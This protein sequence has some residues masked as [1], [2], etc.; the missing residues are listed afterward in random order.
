MTAVPLLVAL[1]LAAPTCIGEVTIPHTNRPANFSGA[2]GVYRIEVSAEPTKV[3]VEDPITLIV[4]IISQVPGP[5]PYPP[6]RD[7]LQLWPPE[8]E[9]N[10]FIEPLPELDRFMEREK[11]W[12]FTWRLMPKSQKVT[13]IPALEFVYYHTAGTPDFQAADGARSIALDVQPRPGLLL[14][15]P[16]GKR[17][18]FQQV[19]EGD[20]LL[21]LRPPAWARLATVAAGL[22]LP[23]LACV[24]A[25]WLW[26]RL[27]P[28]AAERLRR[29]RNRALKT[30][31]TQLGKL[32]GA[33]TPADVR[34]VLAGYLR[35]QFDLPPGEP[36]PSEVK[37]A[38]LLRGLDPAAAAKAESILQTFDATLFAPS[39]ARAGDNLKEGATLLMRNVEAEL[40]ARPAR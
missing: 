11:A 34:A 20:D 23:P 7:K 14:T 28:D 21:I 8:L 9:S 35:L 13:S 6:Q 15:A 30:A 5:W 16:S 1:F 24:L 3:Q 29:G 38:L 10:F 22:A 36:T 2:A 33:A 12:E 18:L 25:C 27:F 37:Q 17:E 26:R 4:K 32:G 31:L 19:V 39:S 40:C